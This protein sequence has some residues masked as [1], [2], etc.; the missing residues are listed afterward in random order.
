MSSIVI[1]RRIIERLKKEAEKLGVSLDEYIVELSSRES[2]PR[3]K[4]LEYVDAAYELIDQ[5]RSELTK[6]NIRHVAE[7]IW[8]AVA[9]TIKAYAWWKEGKRLVS[10]RELWEYKDKLAE[11]YGEWIDIAWAQANSMHT[12]FYEG[13][14]SRR[15]VEIALK[16]VERL[17]REISSRIR[18]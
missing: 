17:V 1:P 10:H 16:H 13:W 9:L 11:E 6:S 14:C 3:D 7:K 18:G 12:C 5:A 2:D 4:A 8:G 15:S